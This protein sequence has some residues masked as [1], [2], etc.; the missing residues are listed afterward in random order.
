VSGVGYQGRR[1]LGSG[2]RHQ[3]K[4]DHASGKKGTDMIQ[5]GLTHLGDLHHKMRKTGRH[6]ESAQPT[7]QSMAISVLCASGLLPAAFLAVAMTM[8][9]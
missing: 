3:G 2:I 4:R 5:A 9:L 6:C 8:N 7:K 1:G